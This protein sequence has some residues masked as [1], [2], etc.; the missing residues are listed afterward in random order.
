M[1]TRATIVLAV[2]FAALAGTYLLSGN[3]QQRAAREAEAAKR[4]F[5]FEPDDVVSLSVERVEGGPSEAV[6]T[7]G[8][9]WK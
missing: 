4:V 5:D 6:R 1:S 8:G 2:V 3:L 9:A 7:A